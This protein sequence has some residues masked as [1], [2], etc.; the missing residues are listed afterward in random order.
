VSAPINRRTLTLAAVLILAVAT[1]SLAVTARADAFVYWANQDNDTIG[2]AGID[3][4]G[5]QQSFIT[6]ADTPCGVAVSDA[7]ASFEE[8]F[9][10]WANSEFP[11]SIGRANVDGTNVDQTF[12]TGPGNPCGVAVDDEFVYWSDQAGSIGRAELDGTNVNG[13]FI[14]ANAANAVAVDGEFI[15]WT[16]FTTGTIGRAELDGTNVDQN[17]IPAA[18]VADPTGVAVDDE[19]V[20]WTNAGG[21]TIGA[22]TIGRADLDGSSPDQSFVTGLT[23]P[24][25]VTVDDSFVYWGNNENVTIGRADLD[26]TDADENFIQSDDDM[27]C[28]VAVNADF[29]LP[30]TS[31]SSLAFGDQLVDTTSPSQDV[32]ITNS[33]TTSVALEINEEETTDL[34][35]F[36]T[37]LG[38]QFVTLAP[39]Q[40][41]TTTVDF[42]P[43]S[44]GGK[45][46]FLSLGSNAGPILVP[47]SGTGADPNQT[48]SPT[49]L[50]FGG[51]L[52]GSTSSAKTVTVTNG[53]GATADDEVGEVVILGPDANQFSI[54]TDG[55]SNQTLPVDGSCEVGVEFG[56][57][58]TGAK[59]AR[60]RIPS[61]TDPPETAE[62][63][64]SGTGTNPDEDVSP[65]SINFGDQ[66]V[67][68]NTATE[69]ITV[70]NTANGT[71]PLL[72]GDISLAGADPAQFD[73]VFDGCSD[74]TL[75]PGDQCPVGVRFAPNAAGGAAASV[76]IPSNGSPSPVSVTLAGTGTAQPPSPPPPLPPSNQFTIDAVKKDKRNGRATL[77][78]TVPGPG[79]LGLSGRGVKERRKQAVAGA[80]QLPVTPLGKAKRRLK[81]EGRARVVLEVTF[82]PNGGLPNTETRRVRL[83]RKEPRR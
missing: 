34:E 70:A 76:E 71:G 82:T 44:V 79:V 68:G 66:V 47:L 45:S 8:D 37:N 32:T 62:V 59:Q 20:Y 4:T 23:Q 3:G 63:T 65:T 58:S 41:C 21:Q 18:V 60:V 69:T 39:G 31:P 50:S 11:G 48:V 13:A 74:V 42:S 56:P 7:G 15:Y 33:S 80:V 51:Q 25:G 26:G 24:C 61:I 29:P 55:C 1:V 17:F 9:L 49:S 73:L 16:N 27:V 64:L 10:F 28:G 72:V 14:P 54:A 2:F 67:N 46:A 57:S 19:F 12:I 22:D 30:D 38:C 75:A 35:E 77:R 53:P 36:N 78:A 6:G 81:R 52:V 43:I 83:V 40:S 5:P